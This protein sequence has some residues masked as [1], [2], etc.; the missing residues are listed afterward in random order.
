MKYNMSENNKKLIFQKN[1]VLN[2]ELHNNFSVSIETMGKDLNSFEK[3]GIIDLHI[4]SLYSFDGHDSIEDLCIAAA[5]KGMTAIAITDHFDLFN[6]SRCYP[7]YLSIEKRLRHDM[8]K[9]VSHF[10]GI[11][12]ILFGVELGNPG[13]YPEIAKDLV[14]SRQFD[15]ILGAVHF[16]PG[17]VD[18]YYIDYKNEEDVHQM[19][20][21]YF[22]EIESLLSFGGFDS[23]AHL[24]YPLRYLENKIS[25]CSIER[26]ANF[27]EPILKR[28]ADM[29]L[30]LEVN[31]RGLFDWQHRVDPEPWVLQRFRELGGK[32]ITIG[33]DSHRK[34]RIGSG[35]YEAL[36]TIKA[37]GFDSIA[38][39]RERKP[40]QVQIEQLLTPVTD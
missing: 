19:F 36:K 27:V 17:G 22:S 35:F 10:R 30:A 1:E 18:I 31:T 20:L 12:E 6:D 24:S 32:Y 8:K 28:T 16:L 33:S 9:A 11:P 38:I 4:H 21:S 2:T 26:Y 29:G 39:F 3:Q 5:N 15:F 25:V 14:N 40:I 23:L 37:A 34:E 7:H 13:H